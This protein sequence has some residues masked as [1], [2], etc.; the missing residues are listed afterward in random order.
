[1]QLARNAAP[2]FFLSRNQAR[3]QL[4]QLLLGMQDFPIA[5]LQLPF[6]PQG[7][8]DGKSGQQQSHAH[9]QGHDQRQAAAQAAE[10]FVHPGVRRGH[11][12]RAERIH[13]VHHLDQLGPM[14]ANL[15][16]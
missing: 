12:P 14:L 11:L 1:M 8:P 15:V 6:Q 2:L 16:G 10:G 3:G 5:L 13:L 4:L 7:S 9:G